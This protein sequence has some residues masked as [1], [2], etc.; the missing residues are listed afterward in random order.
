MIKINTPNGHTPDFKE[1][2]QEVARGVL[3]PSFVDEADFRGEVES[4]AIVRAYQ[5]GMPP[6]RATKFLQ[7]LIDRNYS[8]E[9]VICPNC[10]GEGSLGNSCPIICHDCN[11]AGEIVAL[12]KKAE[13]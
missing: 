10:D 11:G 3:I 4:L 7:R 12:V 8:P 6:E 13:I 1:W 9:Q 2:I 5:K